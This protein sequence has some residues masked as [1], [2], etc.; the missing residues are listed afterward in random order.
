M[1]LVIVLTGLLLANVIPD[2]PTGHLAYAQTADSSIDFA[3]NGTRAVGTFRAYD[4]DGDAIVWSLRAKDR[5]NTLSQSKHNCYAK[6][7]I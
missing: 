3:E 2:D 7:V 4:Q 5:R 6:S 1:P